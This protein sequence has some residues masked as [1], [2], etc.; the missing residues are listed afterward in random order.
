VTAYAMAQDL[1]RPVLRVAMPPGPP[2]AVAGLVQ[3]VTGVDLTQ[4]P[5]C[6]V[7]RLRVVAIFR[8]GTRLVLT[9]D[10]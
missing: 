8:A 4:C 10:T 9:L 3:R 5:E 7:G 2:E 6:G 1:L